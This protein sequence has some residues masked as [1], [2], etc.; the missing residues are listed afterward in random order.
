MKFLYQLAILLIALPLLTK[1]QSNYKPGYAITAKGD[2][3]R[4]LIDYQD[5]EGS[6]QLFRFKA[7]STADVQ[8]LSTANTSYVEISQFDAY[9]KY[10]VDISTDN[11]DIQ[12]LETFRDT[13]FRTDTVFLKIIQKG[14]NV[15]LYSFTD[16]L[17]TRFL[18]KKTDSAQPPHELIYR[19]YHSD[20]KTFN[21]NTYV[22]QLFDLAAEI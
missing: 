4:G 15:T 18:V 21:D 13:S 8:R 22:K 3:L 10:L 5:W 16:H 6:P 19:I 17:K 7:S 14:K 20:Y 1:A 9:Q 11:T 2:T 12:H